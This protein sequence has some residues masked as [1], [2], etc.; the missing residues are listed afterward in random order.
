MKKLEILIPQYKEPDEVIKPLLD[1]I[2]LQQGVNL[3]RDVG[4]IIVNDGTDVLLSDEL[5]NSYDFDITYLKNEKNMGISYTRNRAFDNSTAEYVMFCDDDDMFFSSLG[6]YTIFE[7]MNETMD[8]GIMGFDVL[9]PYFK[10]EVENVNGK[11]IYYN[12]KKDKT[13]NH[14]KIY[15]RRYLLD[16]NIRFNTN[17]PLHEDVYFNALA[18]TIGTDIKYVENCYY[19]WRNNKNSTTRKWKN[20]ILDTIET[21]IACYY[22]LVKEFMKR[23]L[24][25]YA[26][27][28]VANGLYRMYYEAQ[29]QK[30]ID[31]PDRLHSMEVL[32]KKYW[33]EYKNLYERA[34]LDEKVELLKSIKP[35]FL[36][37]VLFEK[38]KFED[39]LKHLEELEDD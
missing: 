11:T 30:F 32:M 25:R 5:L 9:V 2:A 22:E 20:F 17:V 3:K 1:S 37:E 4:V 23:G 34:T 8:S 19:V 38:F 10:E 33:L 21:L 6:L 15:R 39:W 12:H 24:I 7:Y 31:N 18:L 16:N 35:A 29:T 27:V 14:G 13:F 28:N 36:E 26:I